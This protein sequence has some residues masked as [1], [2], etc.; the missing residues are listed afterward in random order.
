MSKFKAGDK[1]VA[2]SN[3]GSR[4]F[5]VGKTY[6]VETVKDGF[7]VCMGDHGKSSSQLSHRWKLA[8]ESK[9]V[10]KK[11][12]WVRFKDCESN[13]LTPEAK[14][15]I[16]SVYEVEALSDIHSGVSLVGVSTTPFSFGYWSDS[17]FERV[18]RPSSFTLLWT[19]KVG[20]IGVASSILYVT[21]EEAVSA[22]KNLMKSEEGCIGV[23]ELRAKVSS[24]M[25]TLVEEV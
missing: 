4:H 15:R 10:F 9:S 19:D 16:G 11:G 21:K 14:A 12:D 18:E 25:E 13:R 1:V 17:R 22:A 7:V 6:I 2:V 5:T 3:A 24:K 23:F 20:P 8:V